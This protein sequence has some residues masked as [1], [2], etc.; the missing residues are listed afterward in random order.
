MSGRVLDKLLP[1]H[2]LC[3][4][5]KRKTFVVHSWVGSCRRTVEAEK[6]AENERGDKL[7]IAH[8][9]PV[10][11]CNKALDFKCVGAKLQTIEQ[12]IAASL[13]LL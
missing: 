9:L 2:D 6:A 12:T 4:D 8:L 3:A 10:P 5:I 1:R 7:F 13:R 11:A